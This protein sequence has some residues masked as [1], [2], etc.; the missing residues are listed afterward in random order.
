MPH[1]QLEPPGA[2]F[3]TA[4]AVGAPGRIRAAGPP[5]EGRGMKRFLVVAGLLLGG[6]ALAGGVVQLVRVDD[7]GRIEF[8]PRVNTDAFDAWVVEVEATV[9][10]ASTMDDAACE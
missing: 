1:V 10:K 3:Q 2:L 6:A 7:A 9:D 8:A 4:S 5:G